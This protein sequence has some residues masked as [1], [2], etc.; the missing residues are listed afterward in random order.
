MCE[1]SKDF[2]SIKHKIK[3]T[4]ILLLDYKLIDYKMFTFK[5]GKSNQPW[6]G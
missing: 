2:L 5:W 3:H 4:Y 1:K 6:E